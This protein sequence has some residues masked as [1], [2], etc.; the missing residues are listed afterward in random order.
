MYFCQ[1]RHSYVPIFQIRCF[2]MNMLWRSIIVCKDRTNLF[3]ELVGEADGMFSEY[4]DARSVG[5]V[6]R[7]GRTDMSLR[8]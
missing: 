4:V 1:D 3:G 2:P 5:L 8:G 7:Y 6:P